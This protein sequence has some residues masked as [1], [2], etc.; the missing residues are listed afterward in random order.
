MFFQSKMGSHV[1]QRF[2]S[3][4]LSTFKRQCKHDQ[5]Y[6]N[7]QLIDLQTML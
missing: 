5:P 7:G 2:H 4:D 1:G 6:Y 3:L